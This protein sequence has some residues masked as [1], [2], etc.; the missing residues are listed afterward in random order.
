M[1]E[2]NRLIWIPFFFKY[3][4]GIRTES[5]KEYS[6]KHCIMNLSVTSATSMVFFI[7]TPASSIFKIDDHD[8]AELLLKVTG[9]TQPLYIHVIRED[10]FVHDPD[11]F[12]IFVIAST[13][14]FFYCSPLALSPST[15]SGFVLL[16][17]SPKI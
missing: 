6:I 14:N 17:N 15:Q 12:S 11:R 1:T 4:I 7:Y 3:Y 5:C 9:R 8:I 2:S 16:I 13:F 10:F